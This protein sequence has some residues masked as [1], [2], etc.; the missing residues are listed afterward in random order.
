MNIA[1]K[2]TPQRNTQYTRMVAQLAEPEL[3]ASPLGDALG[4]IQHITLAGQQY[5][6]A[7][8]DEER[9]EI[10]KMPECGPFCW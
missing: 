10:Q 9:I 5:L 8:V 6:L 2:I 7:R 4:G 1:L 3:L